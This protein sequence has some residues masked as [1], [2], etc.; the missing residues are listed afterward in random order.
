MLDNG[1]AIVENE[2]TQAAEP[3]KKFGFLEVGGSDESRVKSTH[4]QGCG[5]SHREVAA[6][7]MRNRNPR[8]VRDRVPP[9]PNLVSDG[10]QGRHPTIVPRR[11]PRVVDDAPADGYHLRIRVRFANL[12]DPAGLNETVVVNVRDDAAAS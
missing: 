1:I 8:R 5:S 10:I 9:A 7:Q 3:P 4:S 12:A 6:R 11:M 2:A